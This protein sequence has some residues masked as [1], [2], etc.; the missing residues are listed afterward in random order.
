ML[1]FF[2]SYFFIDKIL[3]MTGFEPPTSGI[4]SNC[5][6]DCA[7]TTA[8]NV[9]GR[10][11]VRMVS[12]FYKPLLVVSLCFITDLKPSQGGLPK[13]ISQQKNSLKDLFGKHSLQEEVSPHRWSPVWL[14]WIQL[15]HLVQTNN[16]TYSCFVKYNPV[17]LKTS[18]TVILPLMVGVLWFI[19]QIVQNFDILFLRQHLRLWSLD[20]Q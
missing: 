10:I 16:N 3:P 12:S 2:F 15:F 18:R 6:T 1:F 9:W 5:S 8:H 7:T 13:S 20:L 17:R 4:G 19:Y 11:A 14:V